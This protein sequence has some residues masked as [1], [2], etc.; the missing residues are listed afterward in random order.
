MIAEV[1]DTS[2]PTPDRALLD[3]L[4]ERRP[5][6]FEALVASYQDRLYGLAWRV[7]GSREDAEE[8]VQDALVNAHRAL[9]RTYMRTRVSEL[10]LR[11]WLF[12]A[13]LNAARN[14]VRGR[15]PSHSLEEQ[16]ADGQRRFEPQADGPGLLAL[17][18]NREL[19]AALEQALLNLPIRYR[20]AVVLRWVEDLSYEEVATTLRRPVGT[21]KSDVHRGLR[22]LRKRMQTW[23]D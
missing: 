17:A 21:V 9:Y 14:R 15:R 18:E 20:A 23:L 11:P 7:T 4:A 3:G 13:T 16:T 1:L 10:R 6:A 8:A 22:L 2:Q 12:A 5:G 19:G